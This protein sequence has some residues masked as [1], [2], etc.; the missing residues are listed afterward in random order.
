MLGGI[1]CRQKLL[2]GISHQDATVKVLQVQHPSQTKASNQN[3]NKRN[4]KFIKF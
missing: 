3:V 2:L 4:S 1:M